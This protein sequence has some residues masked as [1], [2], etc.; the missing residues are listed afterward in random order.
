[1]TWSTVT[2]I[3]VSNDHGYVPFD[4][5]TIQVMS[6]FMSY[7]LVYNK[8]NTTDATSGAGT[9]CPARAPEYTTIF[10]DYCVFVLDMQFFVALF[11]SS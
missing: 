10:L 9:A 11:V 7:H 1:M 8:N 3:A 6:S 5:I 2:N 4:V